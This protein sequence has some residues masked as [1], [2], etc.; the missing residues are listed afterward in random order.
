ML[1]KLDELYLL[2]KKKQTSRL[3]VA[4]AQDKQVLQAVS[5]ASVRGIVEPILIGHEQQIK[6][7]CSDLKTDT[8]SFTIIHESDPAAACY[9]AVSLIKDAKGDILMKGLVP[10]APFLKAIL[11][12]ETGIKKDDLLSH[13]ALF[14]IPG[15]HKLL[16]V[17]D[18]AMNIQPDVNE[19]VS[20]IR[21]A[22]DVFHR[23]GQKNPKIAVIGPVEVVNQKIESTVHASML[24]LMNRRGQIS[25][26]LIDGP[27]ALDNAVNKEAAK[28]KGI[29]SDVAGDVDIILTPDLNSG[30]ILYKSLIFLAGSIS[31]AVVMGA[32]SPVVLT[33]RADSD[34]SKLM[35]IVLAAALK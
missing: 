22:V 23:L 16:A 10:T 5:M 3:V 14:E 19:K 34:I 29:H 2:A 15:Y 1:K 6:E 7:I 21:N 31:A 20:I 24:T 4:A 12:N 9:S 27:L 25:G 32:A 30:N 33:S 8:S 13:L 17:T 28:H 35:S 26:C 11:N 18:A